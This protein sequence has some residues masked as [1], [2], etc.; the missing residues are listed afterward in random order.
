VR[1][2]GLERVEKRITGRF[3]FR[4]AFCSHSSP[5]LAV[6]RVDATG[7][8]DAFAGG[9][10][11]APAERQPL[12]DAARLASRVAALATTALGA[13]TALPHRRELHAF[14]RGQRASTHTER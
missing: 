1:A 9:L 13:Q 8:G 12:P 4:T 7:A 6:E 14:L 5:E 2:D 3:S 10:A 11:A